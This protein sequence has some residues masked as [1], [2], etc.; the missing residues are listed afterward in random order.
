MSTVSGS[1][2]ETL[3]L[4]QIVR[5]DQ[6]MFDDRIKQQ[7]IPRAEVLTVLQNIQNAR[8]FSQMSASKKDFDVVVEWMNVC[9]GTIEENTSCELGGIKSSTNVEEYALT[10]ERSWGFTVD[11]SDFVDNRF[12]MEE[13]IAKLLLTGDK[14]LTENVATYAISRVNTFLGVNEYTGGKGVVAG[15]ETSIAAAYWNADLMA[16][17]NTAAVINKFDNP[18]LLSGFN[19]YEQIFLAAAKAGNANGKGDPVLFGT[20]PTYFDLF[21]IDTVNGEPTTYMI[22]T[23]AIAFANKAY[24]PDT[25]QVVNGVFTRYT[26]RSKFSGLVY[27]VFYKPECGTNDKVIHNF[28]MKLKA[29]LFLNPAGCL[30]T[31]TGIL[32]YVCG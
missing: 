24:N 5:A 22:N 27:D 12:D 28:K 8:V 23:G 14:K 15:T 30:A 10:Y 16:Y 21:N 3:L 13:S 1:F 7:F 20:I 9:E 26:M 25:P 2:D 31:N 18:I 29:D 6:I 32:K 4:D 11:E 17:F 19:L